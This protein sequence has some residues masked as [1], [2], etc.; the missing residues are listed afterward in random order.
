M[1]NPFG[2]FCRRTRRL[3]LATI[4][5][6]GSPGFYHL[7]PEEQDRR[8]KDLLLQ[9]RGRKAAAIKRGRLAEEAR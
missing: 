4:A 7:P 1:G 8:F 9:S 5:L 6:C 2:H 3:A